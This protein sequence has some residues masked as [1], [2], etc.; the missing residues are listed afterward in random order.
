MSGIRPQAPKDASKA[1]SLYNPLKLSNK[2]LLV[3]K[4]CHD[5]QHN[6]IQHNDTGN[7]KHNLCNTMFFAVMLSVV[8]A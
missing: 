3:A 8:K 6:G 2:L 7:T 1:F 4:E 5:I